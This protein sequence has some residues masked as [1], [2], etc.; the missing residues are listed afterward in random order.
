[1]KSK[2]PP[3]T[4]EPSVKTKGLLKMKHISIPEFDANSKDSLDFPTFIQQ[5]EAVTEGMDSQLRAFYLKESLAKGSKAL[6]L[7]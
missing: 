2:S 5:V 4:L 1:M 6:R 7:V 3:K